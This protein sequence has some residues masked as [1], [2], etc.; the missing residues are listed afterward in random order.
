MA[1]DEHTIKV[2]ADAYGAAVVQLLAQEFSDLSD[3][4][5]AEIV[6]TA[7]AR[8]AQT[9]DDAFEA[10]VDNPALANWRLHA[11]DTAGRVRIGCFRYPPAARDEDRERRLNEAL[12]AL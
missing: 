5:T 10:I 2:S 3:E 9:P 7:V 1:T 6:A 8:H 12:D 11:H 4:A